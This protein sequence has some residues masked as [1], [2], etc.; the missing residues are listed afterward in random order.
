MSKILNCVNCE[1][2][3]YLT[4]IYPCET[5]V[6]FLFTLCYGIPFNRKYSRYS[7]VG[8]KSDKNWIFYGRISMMLL[9]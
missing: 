1:P 6:G 9:K 2:I 5:S 8:L 3:N 4:E 7:D